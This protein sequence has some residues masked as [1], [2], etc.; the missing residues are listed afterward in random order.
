M[1][2]QINERVEARVMGYKLDKLIKIEDDLGKDEKEEMF[3]KMFDFLK[4]SFV[5][6]ASIEDLSNIMND[7]NYYV[8]HKIVR[9]KG[10]TR[11]YNGAMAISTKQLIIQFIK[12]DILG[13]DLRSLLITPIFN[14]LPEYVIYIHEDGGI[15]LFNSESTA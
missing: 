5:R 11:F 1:K 6:I 10:K 3:F 14:I 13:N 4:N 9:Y 8:A 12:E 7:G 15:L 2:F